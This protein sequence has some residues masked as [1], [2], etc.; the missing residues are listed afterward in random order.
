M[1]DILYQ[2]TNVP[3]N[4]ASHLARLMV[5]RPLA[6][7]R[8][9]DPSAEA[10]LQG[11]LAV[12]LDYRKLLVSLR[13]AGWGIFN[14]YPKRMQKM[15]NCPPS[16]FVTDD[17]DECSCPCKCSWLC[18]WC[19]GRWVKD[20][21]HRI[22]RAIAP[23]DRLTWAIGR[24]YATFDSQLRRK[25]QKHRELATK[26]N[27]SNSDCKGS[28]VSVAAEPYI[29]KGKKCVR[30]SHRHVALLQPSEQF[31]LIPERYHG[32]MANKLNS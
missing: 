2:F 23:G 17:V 15:R 32:R 9:Y 29:R 22:D 18:P 1:S 8:I 27:Q 10:T 19:Y 6:G 26:L 7:R 3:K 31:Q 13:E 5:I 20:V 12:L 21:F 25:L 16:M 11:G 24:Y 30:V 4:P 28:I 14:E